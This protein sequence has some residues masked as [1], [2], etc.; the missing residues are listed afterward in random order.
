M[1]PFRISNLRINEIGVPW[2]SFI[3]RSAVAAVMFMIY[4]TSD[5]RAAQIVLCS[6]LRCLN[7]IWYLLFVIF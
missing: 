1:T 3:R 5:G 7:S 2:F 4:G 6:I